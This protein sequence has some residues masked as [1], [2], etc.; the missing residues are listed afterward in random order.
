MRSNSFVHR[1]GIF[2]VLALTLAVIAIIF[3]F[4][5]NTP[6]SEISEGIAPDPTTLPN[7]VSMPTATSF[8]VTSPIS[9]LSPLSI[10]PNSTVTPTNPRT[11]SEMTQS[12]VEI[13]EQGDYETAIEI[14]DDVLA[15]IPDAVTYNARGSAY[16]A[17]GD[18]DKALD[19]YYKAVE[20]HPTFPH[21]IYNRGR[22]FS[23]LKRYDDALI[24]LQK[25]VEISPFEFG[26]RANGNI[27]L[28]YHQLGEYD[29]ALE[30][31]G[32][33][34]SQNVE[35]KA[36]VY[37]FRGETYT[38]LENYEAAIADYEA[39]IERFAQYGVAYQSLGYAYYKIEEFDKALESLNHAVEITPESPVAHLYLALV[40]LATDQPDKAISNASQ[41]VNSINTL[42]EEEQ[43]LIFTRILA[44]L[45]ALSQE[46][47][48]NIEAV[49]TIIDII[50]AQ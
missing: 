9:P 35:E 26:Y 28:I 34:I 20:L 45:D 6:D 1:W 10:I 24:D 50:P 14:F 18:Y 13:Y 41:G 47:P 38:M 43:N 25:A 30:A 7:N 36:D 22:L 31:F 3:Y 27:G 33:S 42:S 8:S 21:A 19:D 49:E 12:G 46:Q 44:D 39:A 40:Y 11:L 2:L 15:Q 5:A 32:E 16:L 29:K 23:I 4:V 37:Y 17:L 48:D